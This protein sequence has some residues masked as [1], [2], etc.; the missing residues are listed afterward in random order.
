MEAEKILLTVADTAEYL[1]LGKTKTREFMKLH[2]KAFVIKIGNRSYTHKDLL[3]KWLMAEI[4][5]S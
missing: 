1:N 5:R 3:D 2:E 4:R